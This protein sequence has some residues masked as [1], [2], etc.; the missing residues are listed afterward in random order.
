MGDTKAGPTLSIGLPVR[1]GA[2]YLERTLECLRKQEF[3]DVEVLIADNASTDET[4]QI[5][6]AAADSDPRIRYVRHAAD[7]GAAEN[8]NYVYRETR[9]EFFAWLAAD[10]MFEPGFYRRMIEVLR[11]RPEAAAAISRVKLIDPDDNFVE[12]ADEQTHADFPD[13]VRR[14][15]EMASYRHFCQFS[16]AVARRAAMEKTRL[17]LPFWTSDRLYCA[18]LALVGPLV[19]DPEPLFRIRQHP[20]RVTRRIGRKDWA[21]QRFYL[22]PT[23]SRAVTLYYAGQLRESIERSELTPSDKARARRALGVWAVRNSPKLLRSAGRKAMELVDRR[24]RTPAA[25]AG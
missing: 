7:R 24:G 13:P 4:E 2:R 1:N 10:D 15:A 25:A 19:R 12:Y 9:G 6:R 22:T 16:F 20:E 21:I 23:G 3:E 11:A 14:F 5:A 8:F 18:E 17:L